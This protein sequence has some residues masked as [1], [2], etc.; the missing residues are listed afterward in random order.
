MHLHALEILVWLLLMPREYQFPF[1]L[2]HLI[3]FR[4]VARTLHFRRAA[5]SLAVAQPA[6]SRQVASLE[7]SLGAS[8]FTRTRRRVELT[9]AGRLLLEKTEPM[10]RSLAGMQREIQALAEGSIGHVRVAFTGLAMATVLPRILREFHRRHPG[11][12]VEL[13]ESP[14]ASQLAALQSGELSCGFFH[15]DSGGTPG[16]RTRLLLRERNGV[17]LPADHPLAA[18]PTLRLR[19]LAKTPFVL[20]PRAYNPS[21]YDRVL[22]AF[23][24][25]HVAPRIAEEVW[26]RA[27]GIGL[28]RAGLGATFVCP[29]E[30]RQLPPEV[31]LRELTGPAPESRLVIGW[32]EPPSPAPSLAAFLA[33][34]M[35]DE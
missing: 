34:A 24:Q 16:L 29:S 20:F 21:F 15:P 12:R 33:V 31:V 17:L 26:P 13:S 14:T 23:A 30:V 18:R 28:V 25:S 2:R 5:E 3:Y 35:Q 4:E 11:I 6:L 32:R 7:R 10:L 27:N 8:L 22:A 19:E 1:E 9:P